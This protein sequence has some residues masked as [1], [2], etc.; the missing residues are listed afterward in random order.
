MSREQTKFTFVSTNVL[1]LTPASKLQKSPSRG[2]KHGADAVYENKDLQ[3]SI[4]CSLTFASVSIDRFP[5]K[6][7]LKDRNYSSFIYAGSEADSRSLTD[8]E[9]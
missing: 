2:E 3:R 6:D 7:E 4:S 8:V 5:Q 9:S 1:I